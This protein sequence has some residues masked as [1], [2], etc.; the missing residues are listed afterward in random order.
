MTTGGVQIQSAPLN[1]EKK[2]PG[3]MRNKGKRKREK[4]ETANLAAQLPL[5]ESVITLPA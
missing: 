3:Q 1:A 4:E 2:R 5:Y